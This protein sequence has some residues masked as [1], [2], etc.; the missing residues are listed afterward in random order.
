M[1]ES[2]G[3]LKVAVRVR[4]SEGSEAAGVGVDASEAGDE[5]DLAERSSVQLTER[6]EDLVAP[7]DD[8]AGAEHAL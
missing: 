1:M 8:L 4:V 2:S 6:A 5:D 7:V 3:L